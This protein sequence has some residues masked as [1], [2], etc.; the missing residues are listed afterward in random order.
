LVKKEKWI[1][2]NNG[3]LINAIDNKRKPRFLETSEFVWIRE[4]SSLKQITPIASLHPNSY[5]DNFLESLAK[6][7]YEVTDG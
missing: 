6:G 2:L 4:H 1:P 5:L 7:M 3:D